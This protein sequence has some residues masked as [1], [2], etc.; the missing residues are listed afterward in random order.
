MPDYVNCAGCNEQVSRRGGESWHER[1]KCGK[2]LC[3]RCGGQTGSLC[4]AAPKGTAGCLG[5]LL[6]K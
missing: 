2:I 5:T 4:K 1:S 6:K 3:W